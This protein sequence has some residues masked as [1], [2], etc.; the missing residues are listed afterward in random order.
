MSKDTKQ[1]KHSFSLLKR[2]F[3]GKSKIEEMDILQEETLES[4]MRTILKNFKENRLAM[5]GLI[6]FVIIF[7]IVLIGPIFNPISLNE[8]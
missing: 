4:P 6:I 8:K 3:G 7:A 5:G 2:L 1:K